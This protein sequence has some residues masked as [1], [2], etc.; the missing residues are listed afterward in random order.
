MYKEIKVTWNTENNKLKTHNDYFVPFHVPSFLGSEFDFIKSNFR[1]DYLISGYEQCNIFFESYYPQSSSFL[2]NSCSSALEVAL[3]VLNV[4]EGDEVIIPGFGYVAVA[5]AVLIN[6]A[7]PV[8]ADVSAIDGNI[9]VSSIEKSI[10]PQTKAVIAIHYAGRAFEIDSIL[11]ICNKYGIYLIEDAAQAMGVKFN[12]QPLGSFGDIACLSFDYMKNISCGQGGLLIVNNK[13]LNDRAYAMLENGVNKKD[14]AMGRAY[15]FDW[16]CAGSN[17]KMNPIASFFLFEHLK[18]Y[19]KI[20]F[21]RISV[22]N[23][24]CSLLSNLKERGII[25]FPE[26]SLHHNGHIFFII[27]GSKEE[28]QRLRSYLR[29]KHIFCEP[30]Y[31]LLTDTTFGR[32]VITTQNDLTA[33][34][35]FCE[36]LL[37]LPIWNSISSTHIETVVNAIH[38]FYS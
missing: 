21:Q 28:K 29:E 30:H 34:K 35:I 4:K 20:T 15:V 33:S 32:E 11:Q 9:D 7:K 27:T 16:L 8:L 25:R 26:L 19:E 31:S 6:G 22:W 36:S 2:V 12:G 13:N 37:R 5:N 14:L 38:K 1:P 24:Y 18:E 23:Y 17:L 10:T 3:R